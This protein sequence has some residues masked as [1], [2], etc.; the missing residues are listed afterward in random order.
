MYD[1]TF[2]NYFGIALEPTSYVYWIYEITIIEYIFGFT[3]RLVIFSGYKKSFLFEE[4][5]KHWFNILNN[6]LLIYSLMYLQCLIL[7]NIFINI[8]IHLL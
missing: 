1:I 3:F 6:I 2:I 8:V 7:L 4:K 5:K